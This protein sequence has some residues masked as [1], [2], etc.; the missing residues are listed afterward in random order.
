[1]RCV[2]RY[3]LVLAVGLAGCESDEA[4]PVAIERILVIGNSI[5]YHPPEPAIGWN[6][7]WGMAASS[8]E[9]DYFSRLKDSL[10]LHMPDL[11]MIRENVFPFERSFA[12]LD[13]SQYQELREFDADLLV[14]RLGENVSPSALR[15]WNFSEALQDFSAYLVP[16]EARVILTTTFWPNPEVNQHL[17]H[18][19]SQQGWEVVEL[20]DLGQEARYMALG[21]FSTESVGRHPND[22]GM[23][24]ISQR[25]T[26][27]ILNP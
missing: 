27:Q 11:E 12:S 22:L 10:Q 2:F 7:D 18:A 24:V 20:S 23:A 6:A 15:E 1:M 5:T 9:R 16:S 19:A 8:P 14:I 25:L 4:P 3:F 21:G 17:R 13:Q 26:R